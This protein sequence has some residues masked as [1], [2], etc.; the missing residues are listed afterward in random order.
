MSVRHGDNRRSHRIRLQPIDV[1]GG[2]CRERTPP[3]RHA[4]EGAINVW[5]AF[6]GS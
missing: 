3:D 2:V 1:A 5:V 6:S 4:V